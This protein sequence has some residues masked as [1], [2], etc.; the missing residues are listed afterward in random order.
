[1]Q[2]TQKQDDKE[3]N[4]AEFL[5]NEFVEQIVKDLNLNI[6]DEEINDLLNETKKKD[7]QKKGE[8]EDKD[9]Q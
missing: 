8:D 5:D 2:Q 4:Y 1:M 3:E 6:D 7:E 9:K